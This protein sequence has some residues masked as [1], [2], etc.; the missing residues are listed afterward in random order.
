[1]CNVPGQ[2]TLRKLPLLLQPLMHPSLPRQQATGAAA[3][4]RTQPARLLRTGR[5]SP[6]RWSMGWAA[7]CRLSCCRRRIQTARRARA[8]APP[9]ACAPAG[10]PARLRKVRWGAGMQLDGVS[11][12]AAWIPLCATLVAN[13]GKKTAKLGRRPRAAATLPAWST[14]AA[15]VPCALKPELSCPH[16]PAPPSWRL[17]GTRGT[18]LLAAHPH[19]R[20]QRHNCT[21]G[22][23]CHTSL[24]CRE[25]TERAH[26]GRTAPAGPGTP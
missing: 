16:P 8:A 10:V 12:P 7:V 14:L 19:F 6:S 5:T 1:M 9:G 13:A 25:E 18:T 2:R 3:S 22:S 4:R 17:K 26:P 21:H 24:L 23:Q 11:G 20:H 15:A